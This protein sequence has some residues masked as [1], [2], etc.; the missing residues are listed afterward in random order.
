VS[1]V[2]SE[3]WKNTSAAHVRAVTARSASSL[4]SRDTTRDSKPLTASAQGAA[5]A[6]RGL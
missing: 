2:V 1:D 6:S 4:E 3:L 5:I